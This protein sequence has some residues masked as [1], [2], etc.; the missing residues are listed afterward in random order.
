MAIKYQLGE[1]ARAA[2]RV[3]DQ[4]ANECAIRRW[5]MISLDQWNVISPYVHKEPYWNDVLTAEAKAAQRYYYIND[6]MLDGFAKALQPH[7]DA[8][9][10]EGVA[11]K[12]TGSTK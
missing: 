12:L 4:L 5:A 3:L 9:I 6:H 10:V 11:K 2:R 8:E 1:R 7:I